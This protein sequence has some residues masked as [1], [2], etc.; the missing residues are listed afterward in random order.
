MKILFVGAVDFSVHCLDAVL[1][2]HGQV[3]AV[4]T[5]TEDRARGYSDFADITPLAKAHNIPVH[6][7]R[8]INDKETVQL[9]ASLKPDV[10]FVFGYSQLVS[11]DVL[12][13]PRLGCVGTHPAL[14]PQNR[15]R[16]PLIW[17]LV[18]GLEQG[19]LSFFFLEE[20]A[21]TG[22]ILSQESFPITKTDTAMD[23]YKKIKASAVTQIQKF[24]PLLVNGTHK[25]RP[26]N[27]VHAS[28]WRKRTAQDGKIDW[29]MSIRAIQN[30][31]R[32]LSKPYPGAEMTHHG[33]S[34]VVWKVSEYMGD[35]P[36]NA[37]P[38]KILQIVDSR[39]I[40]KCYDGALL[41]EQLEP[42][43]AFTQGDYIQ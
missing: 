39:P 38:G 36:Q 30:L 13:I 4:L 43:M 8:D 1:K 11:K 34:V 41:L 22:A 42:S 6:K 37:E 33:Q 16:H 18:L 21:D 10:I 9:I 2:N 3:V 19:G 23:L 35:V 25:P 32:A 40:I 15:G 17:S 5:P 29:R 24:L 20:G 12:K 31:V 26:Q 7:I 14:L 27:N 28:S